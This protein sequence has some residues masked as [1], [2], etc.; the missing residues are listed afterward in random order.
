MSA[1]PVLSPRPTRMVLG[2]RVFPP[3]SRF[4]ARAQ[5][6]AA[7]NLRVQA[8]VPLVWLSGLVEPVLYL[9]SIGVGIGHLVGTVPGPTGAPVRYALFVAPALLATSAMN[10][11]IYECTTNIFA[12][13]HWEKLYQAVIAT[14]L[15]PG[16][17]AAAE[18]GV[19]ILRVTLYAGAFLATMALM[20]DTAS[21]WALLSLPAAVLVG[22]AFA[23]T[24]FAA[25]TYMRSWTDFDKINL[26]SIPLF[27]FS[28]TFY[29]LRV[30]P[31]W[32]QIVVECTP[33]YHGVVLCR[34][35]ALGDVGWG[36]LAHGAYLA[37]LATLGMVVA[38]RRVVSLLSP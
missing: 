24:G 10:G 30:Y 13:L 20:G 12:K 7:R 9:L 29:P 3:A 36:L 16:D 11:A 26:V 4:S 8:K 21:W 34:D 15:T 32:L 31:R 38:G 2:A 23:T 22:L 1:R 19:A 27:L 25:T 35:L 5:R 17:V 14:P 33:L 6:L 18:I 37:A 28:T